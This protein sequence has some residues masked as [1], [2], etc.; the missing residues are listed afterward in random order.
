MKIDLATF[1]KILLSLTITYEEEIDCEEC[2]QHMDQFADMLR[3]GEDPAK[4]LPLVKHHLD[5]CGDC[6][7]EFEALSNALTACD[8]LDA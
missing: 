1:K 6:N 5:L 3:E 4:V 8:D 7:E 2:Y